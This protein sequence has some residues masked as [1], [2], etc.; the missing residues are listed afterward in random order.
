MVSITFP[1]V[2]MLSKE[3]M[4]LP[5]MMETRQLNMRIRHEVIVALAFAGL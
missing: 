1:P 2:C 5:Y 3:T 4:M